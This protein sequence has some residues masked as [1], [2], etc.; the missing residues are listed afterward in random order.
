MKTIT[1]FVFSNLWVSRFSDP[2]VV[3]MFGTC[4][5]P[6][7]FTAESS[8]GTVA[9]EIGRLNPLATIIVGPKA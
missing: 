2:E 5:I 9:E 6:T 4:D 7:S 8:A 3:R 1:L